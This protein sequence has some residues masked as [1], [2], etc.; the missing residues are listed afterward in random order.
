MLFQNAESSKKR[1]SF[2]E[3][4]FTK[5]SLFVTFPFLWGPGLSGS[6]HVTRINYYSSVYQPVDVSRKIYSAKDY[7]WKYILTVFFFFP[8][9]ARAF[10]I[11]LGIRQIQ[12]P[13]L[14][15]SSYGLVKSCRPHP[16]VHPHSVQSYVCVHSIRSRKQKQTKT[17]KKVHIPK[18]VFLSQ[19]TP[20]R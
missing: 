12:F 7:F 20:N 16:W 17:L 18:S 14:S 13:G 9:P 19:P 6:Q 8:P 11:G 10:H 5:M 3:I 2:T 4:V 1:K 15:L